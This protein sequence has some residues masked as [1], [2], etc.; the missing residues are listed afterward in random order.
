VETISRT[1]LV[2]VGHESKHDHAKH[3]LWPNLPNVL[4]LGLVLAFGLVFAL[5]LA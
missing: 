1:K 5:T 2:V 3:F 4:S